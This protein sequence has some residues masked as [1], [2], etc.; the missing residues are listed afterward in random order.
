M[1]RRPP[2]SPPLSLHD[3][4]PISLWG[5]RH[6][7]AVDREDRR[8][9]RGDTVG[10]WLGA[11]KH[12]AGSPYH[13]V[14]RFAPI[15]AGRRRRPLGVA[16]DARHHVVVPEGDIDPARGTPSAPGEPHDFPLA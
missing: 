1:I 3:A 7:A 6:P 11:T 5:C 16:P 15:P 8:T 4:L 2:R 12:R 13:V 9:E 10:G 14:L